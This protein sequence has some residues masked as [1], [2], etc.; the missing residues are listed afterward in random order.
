MFILVQ[1][2]Q[3]TRYKPLMDQ[4]FRLRKRVFHDQLGWAVTIDDDCEHDEYDALRPAYL[5]W[6]NDRADRLYGTLRLMP[7]TGPTL[8]YDV[9]RDTFAGASLIA[10]GIYEGTRMC[11]DEETLSEDFPSLETGKAFGML[12]LALCECGLSHGIE[13]LVSNYEPQLARV[14]R[15]AGLAVEEVGRADG[16]GRSPVCCGVFEVSEEVRTRMQQALGVATPLYAGY[17]PHKLRTAR[18]CAYRPDPGVVQRAVATTCA[19]TAIIAGKDNILVDE[20]VELVARPDLD[21]GLNIQV[22][23][24]RLLRDAAEG[25]GKV[26]TRRV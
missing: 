7:T 13:T 12:L 1:A 23:G 20:N 4:A 2:H 9:F 17:R 22:L 14:Y 10:P 3:Y 15:R 26:S 6:C 16:Y 24:N 21:G 18:P 11:L 5:M 8:L 19:S 25:L